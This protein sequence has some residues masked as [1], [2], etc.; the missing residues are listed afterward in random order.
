VQL[1]LNSTSTIT[2]WFNNNV[3]RDK[4]VPHW[5]ACHDTNAT[6]WDQSGWSSVVLGNALCCGFRKASGWNKV[7]LCFE[8]RLLIPVRWSSNQFALHEQGFVKQ[9]SYC[10]C[11]LLVVPIRLL[12]VRFLIPLTLCNF[13]MP[14][15]I[16]YVT[17]AV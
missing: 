2:N 8:V 11:C 14:I 10:I 16:M 17:Y 4:T 13:L 15:S 9:F 7:C 6:C 1:P 3:W 12:V 5:V